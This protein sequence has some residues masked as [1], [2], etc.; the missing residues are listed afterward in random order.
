M[1]HILMVLNLLAKPDKF[2]KIAWG[3]ADDAGVIN[4][5]WTVQVLAHSTVA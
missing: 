1:M 5:Y 3:F 4:R 2:A